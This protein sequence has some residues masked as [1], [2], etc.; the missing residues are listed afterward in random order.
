MTKSCAQVFE[1]K[2]G[3][4]LVGAADFDNA[5]TVAE[6]PTVPDN[7]A[8]DLLWWNESNGSKLWRMKLRITSRCPFAGAARFLRRK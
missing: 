6:D 7:S 2:E 1:G 5:E 8:D 3:F 4:R